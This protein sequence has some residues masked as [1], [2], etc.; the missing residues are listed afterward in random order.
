MMKQREDWQKK[1]P[2]DVRKML[3]AF[4]GGLPALEA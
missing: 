2:Q 4:G 1:L 3:D